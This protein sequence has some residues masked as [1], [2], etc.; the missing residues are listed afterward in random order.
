LAVFDQAPNSAQR[1]SEAAGH[2]VAYHAD[3]ELKPASARWSMAEILQRGLREEPA[4][5]ELD[6]DAAV[7]FTAPLASDPA[8][9]K[10]GLE[11]RPAPFGR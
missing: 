10:N 6:V 2:A 4:G 7:L 5:D 8:P 1:R 9:G 11:R 3:P